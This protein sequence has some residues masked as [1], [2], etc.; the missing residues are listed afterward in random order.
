MHFA[1]RMFF[2][3]LALSEKANPKHATRSIMDS[4]YPMLGLDDYDYENAFQEI[5]DILKDEDIYEDNA[6]LHDGVDDNG[7]PLDEMA[8]D[9]GLVSIC[10]VFAILVPFLCQ[11]SFLCVYLTKMVTLLLAQTLNLV[12]IG[13][14]GF[15]SKPKP[16]IINVG[17][18]AISPA[19]AGSF[20]FT[21]WN[22]LL[23]PVF[24]TCHSFDEALTTVLIHDL[25]L[26]VTKMEVREANFRAF[27]M[28]MVTV[29]VG[30]L[31][32]NFAQII[33]H[34]INDTWWRLVLMSTSP[35]VHVHSAI[36]L[37]ISLYCGI[38][39]VQALIK[40]DRFHA[41]SSCQDG[42]KKKSI[43]RLCF[44]IAFLLIAQFLRVSFR[45]AESI[46]WKGK[47]D[48]LVDSNCHQARKSSLDDAENC[49]ELLTGRG[50]VVSFINLTSC[51][52]FETS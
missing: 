29:L 13:V 1:F 30:S 38:Q 16:P 21:L 45:I 11:G 49:G 48:S 28:K 47:I 3:P 15:Y 36:S 4:E 9:L 31:I 43:V 41:N 34:F 27:A 22:G 37:V 8:L 51:G 20:R 12:F 42:K 6:V 39:I 33:F 2:F 40:S 52:L 18:D 25:Y 32:S 26:C 23:L 5:H 19:S 14:A 17:K 24:R 46:S 44:L 35:T 50:M 10:L 7:V